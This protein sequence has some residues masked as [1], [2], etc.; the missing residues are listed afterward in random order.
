[1]K[2]AENILN[3]KSWWK[4]TARSKIKWQVKFTLFLCHVPFLRWPMSV[5]HDNKF[6]KHNN[7]FV[8]A[9]NLLYYININVHPFN[10]LSDSYEFYFASKIVHCKMHYYFWLHEW[11]GCK[12]NW[13]AIWLVPWQSIFFHLD[14]QHGHAKWHLLS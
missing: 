11:C 5:K 12:Y 10:S 9:M 7:E 8:K 1:M 14:C 4:W 6:V 3:H 13:V 2:A